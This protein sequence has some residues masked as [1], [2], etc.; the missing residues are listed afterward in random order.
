MNYLT[1][2]ATLTL[3]ALAAGWATGYTFGLIVYQLKRY[4]DLM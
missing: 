2:T 4:S 3:G 1:D